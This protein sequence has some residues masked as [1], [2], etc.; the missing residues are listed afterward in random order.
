MDHLVPVE[1]PYLHSMGGGA[2]Q[3]VRGWLQLDESKS[4]NRSEV[5]L[6]ASLCVAVRWHFHRPNQGH[7]GLPNVLRQVRPASE[8]E[9]KIKLGLCQ[10]VS[11]EF[12]LYVQPA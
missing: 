9:S 6:W 10:W 12:G 4:S 2:G 7:D 1:A 5:G 8:D 11:F 3:K